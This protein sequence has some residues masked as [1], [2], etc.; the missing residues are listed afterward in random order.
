MRLVAGHFHAPTAGLVMGDYS[1]VTIRDS[2][3]AITSERLYRTARPIF[4]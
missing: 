4:T 1:D 3:N 2:M